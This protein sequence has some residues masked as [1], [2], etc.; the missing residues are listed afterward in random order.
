MK[1]HHLSALCLAFAA[2]LFSFD[3]SFAE[4][5]STSAHIE[6]ASATLI[7]GPERSDGTVRA[8][9]NLELA[10]GFK[11]Y[12]HV[13][14]D[15]GIPP[16]IKA[17]GE[18]VSVLLPPPQRFQDQYGEALGYEK[19]ASLAMV[20]PAPASR[21]LELDMIV[22]VCAEICIPF[23]ATLKADV[24]DALMPRTQFALDDVF[25]ALPLP[26]SDELKV[27]SAQLADDTEHGVTLRVE[28]DVA[29]E[30]KDDL[31]VYARLPDGE[32]FFPRAASFRQ[33]GTQTVARFEVTTPLTAEELAG[34]DAVFT[35]VA[36]GDSG[37][38]SVE[39]VV[40]LR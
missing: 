16:I 31:A 1:K 35:L 17:Q 6:H 26:F 22:G 20:L 13:P 15:G 19:T 38:R 25:D 18:L 28:L 29:K 5:A 39:G 7:V 12:W 33:I 24:P 10:E 30:L 3:E 9:I 23:I 32:E 21:E 4:G 11:T 2:A 36:Q 37:T 14:G 8:A 27:V 34:R 40:S